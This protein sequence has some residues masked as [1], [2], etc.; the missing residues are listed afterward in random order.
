MDA[1]RGSR[2]N[3]QFAI[4]R[5]TKFMST[6]KK[7]SIVLRPTDASAPASKVRTQFNTLV[8]KLERER[9]RLAAWHD[10]LPVVRS[11]IAEQLV[12]LGDIYQGRMRSMVLLFDEA[13]RTKK[14]TKKEREKLSNI[15]CDVCEELFSIEVKDDG[16]EEVYARHS[17]MG[18]A[19]DE[20][21]DALEN[22][23]A[24]KEFA[25]MLDDMFG[26]ASADDEADDAEQAGTGPDGHGPKRS[27][28]PTAKQ[29]RQAAEEVKLQQSVREIFRKL[30]SALHPD[31]ESD[32]AERARKTA[33]M[34]RVNVAY[35]KNDLL[36]LL[37]LQFEID[38]ID[39][40]GLE[41]M[42]DER[43]KQY[44]K[45]LKKQFDDVHREIR[46]LEDWLA[47]DLAVPHQYMTP[48]A[49]DAYIDDEIV[50]AE[51]RLQQIEHDLDDFTDL[52]N[53]KQFLKAYRM[54]KHDEYMDP[55][56][57]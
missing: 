31:R 1:P 32:P 45:V 5:H 22:D 12:P 19:I 39:V 6:S 20:L 21:E 47:Y 8:K 7:Q 41:A 33:L 37:E 49:L 17:D 35:E 43:I 55:D 18:D 2:Y 14:L 9:Q 3:P 16:I 25:A 23:P 40:A 50:R 52:K 30:V 24:F 51:L 36:A 34:Q 10:K 11:R 38:Q 44:N 42:P 57:F 13:W 53:L 26:A 54:P 4:H 15:I 27:A 56:F 28:K 48:A 29:K 46:D